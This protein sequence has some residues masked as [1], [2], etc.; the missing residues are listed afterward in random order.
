MKPHDVIIA[1]LVLLL[2]ISGA[3]LA[4]SLS[5]RPDLLNNVN[6]NQDSEDVSAQIDGQSYTLVAHNDTEIPRSGNHQ[7]LFED[8]RVSLRLCNTP[9]GEYT[10]TGDRVQGMLISTLMYCE[11]PA[12]LMSAEIAFGE[13]LDA[14]ATVSWEGETLVLKQGEHTMKFEK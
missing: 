14:G 13:M 4:L 2:I 9:S 11:D 10:V 12:Y 7:L 8:G 6:S 5:D 3:Q 1:L